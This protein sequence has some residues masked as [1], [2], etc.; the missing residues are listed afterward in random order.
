[1]R[2][3]LS[4]LVVLWVVSGSA[5]TGVAISAA[6]QADA[7]KAQDLLPYR[8][9]YTPEEIQKNFRPQ[10]FT[11][12]GDRK[13]YFEILVPSGWESHLSDFDPDQLAQDKE[14]PVQ[15][16]DFEPGGGVDDLGIQV[17]YIRAA[18]Q[19]GLDR[20]VTD[21]AQKSRATVVARQR[22][23]L[24][25]GAAEDALLRMN[26]EDLGP[27]LVRI[28][29]LRHGDIVFIISAGTVEEKYEKNKRLFGAVAT[30]FK[31]S[32]K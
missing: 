1:M 3:V 20:I 31:A 8:D 26:S 10:Q 11:P 14:S 4:Q 18:A 7:A 22:A 19:T 30:T 17:L 2:T 13:F 21:Y 27:M 12:F 5:A 25:E 32:G 9:L 29:A 16:A 28:M 6:Q 15:I 24:K 23:E